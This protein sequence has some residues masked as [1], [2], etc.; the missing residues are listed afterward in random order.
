MTRP[1]G[2]NAVSIANVQLVDPQAVSR[3]M[4]R[5]DA[6]EDLVE[7]LQALAKAAGW[8]DAY[9][10]GAGVLELVELS[11]GGETITLENAELLSLAGRINKGKVVLR[12]QLLAG[13]ATKSGT[14]TAAMT[15]GLVLVVDAYTPGAEVRAAAPVKRHDT[16]PSPARQA[17]AAATPAR[18]TGRIASEAPKMGSSASKPLS[19]SFKTKPVVHRPPT[20]NFDDDDHDENPIINTG[21]FLN[22]P[23]LGLCEVVGDDESGGT[24]IR[25]PSGRI[26]VLKLEALRVM[27]GALDEEGRNVFRVAGPRKR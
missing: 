18:P 3:G 25:V 19:Q 17:I 13:G 7:S 21:D 12:A 20:R 15:G 24:R 6:G 8:S 4:V 16:Q 23:Q 11:T 22:H 10:S 5:V 26:R 27:P 14:I 2:A 9:V 1:P